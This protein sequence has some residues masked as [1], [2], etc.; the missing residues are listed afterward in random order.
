MN[1]L[2]ISLIEV[3]RVISIGMVNLGVGD[4]LMGAEMLTAC[5]EIIPEIWK[6]AQKLYA[7]DAH[8]FVFAQRRGY[9]RHHECV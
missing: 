2:E 6:G 5:W 8:E 1:I 3:I 9:T 4:V 7:F